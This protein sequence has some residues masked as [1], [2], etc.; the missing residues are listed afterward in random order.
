MTNHQINAVMIQYDQA[1][2]YRFAYLGAVCVNFVEQI[3]RF[4]SYDVSRDLSRGKT[5]L[6]MI[7]NL[8][9]CG[10]TGTHWVAL[11]CQL[12]PR[13]RANFGAT[14]FDSAGND[15]PDQVQRFVASLKGQIEQR[16]PG[17]TFRLS[18]DGRRRQFGD[19]ECGMF[20]INFLVD[21]IHTCVTG[22]RVEDVDVG[23]DDRSFRSR[24][25]HFRA[26][27]AKKLGS[28]SARATRVKTDR[29]TR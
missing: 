24:S 19:S 22:R 2:E 13:D 14:F 29:E 18:W 26:S 7:V 4:R 28:K 12:D 8:D 21:C 1:P 10:G 3:P 23:D 15:P 9:V 25:V 16:F 27:P 6:G 11:F 17:T 20:C 5:R